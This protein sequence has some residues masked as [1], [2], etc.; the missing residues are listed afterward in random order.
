MVPHGARCGFAA[1]QK[2]GKRYDLNEVSV[3]EEAGVGQQRGIEISE[4]AD[5]FGALAFWAH[6][7]R[8]QRH[9]RENAG[10]AFGGEPAEQIVAD[11]LIV[12]DGRPATGSQLR[13]VADRQRVGLQRRRGKRVGSRCE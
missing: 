2:I 10:F 3:V 8:S 11:D 7:H 9:G 4:A 6:C 13:H 12:L 1:D 5:L